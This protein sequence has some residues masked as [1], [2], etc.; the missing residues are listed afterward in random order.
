MYKL[1][2]TIEQT[3]F[4]AEQ[5]AVIQQ[6]LNTLNSEQQAWLGGYLSRNIINLGQQVSE[7]KSFETEFKLTILVGTQTGNSQN[8]A[9]QIQQKAIKVGIAVVIH[10]LSDYTIVQLKSDKYILLIVSTYGEGE[11][12]DN[13]KDFYSQLFSKRAPKLDHIEFS[14]LALGDSSYEH[15]CKIGKDFDRRF[16]DLGAKRI[17][18]RVDCD[19]DFDSSAELWTT[20]VLDLL[21]TKIA[22]GVGVFLKPQVNSASASNVD[23]SR[24]NPF[25][26]KLLEKV[27]INGRGSSKETYHVELS[28]E[29]SGLTYEPGDALG[30]YPTNQPDII[31]KILDTL[32]FSGHEL[33]TLEGQQYSLE[34]ALFQ[35][36]DITSLSRPII[37]NYSRLAKHATL[38]QLISEDYKNELQAYIYGRDILD[39]ITEY[40]INELS[41]QAFV[42]CLRKLS[43][44]LYSIASS[45]KK[46]PDEVHLTVGVV[47]YRSH[48]RIKHGVAS[49]FLADRI[50]ENTDIPI[51][52]HHNNNF[53]LPKDPN[54]SV[55]MI[56]PGTG[57]APFRAFM[58]ERD[59]VSAK[60]KN[61]LFFGDQHFT[62][63]FLYQAEW[64]RYFKYGLL[65][66]M[67]VAFSRDQ[68]D[69]IYVQHRLAEHA[70]Q[71]YAWL[72]D[73]ASIYVCGDEKN[74]AKDVH[75][76][77]V[78]IVNSESSNDDGEEFLARLLKEKRYQR[79]VY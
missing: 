35:F 72:Q 49:T 1:L 5:H 17:C 63:D 19:V 64:L 21:S 6:M 43:P 29:N 50:N 11:P 7:Q 16:E 12:P 45:L 74:M 62:T 71:L 77:L 79:D 69:K 42:D 32:H 73:G 13:T 18:E 47:R 68:T 38:E 39:L 24:K 31:Q 9:I 2:P 75:L 40:P 8:I 30:I 34:T 14:V 66:H 33:I 20:K 3:P 4:S 22:S 46:H 78:N 60:G 58:Q 61:W 65:T 67:D 54:T 55:I 52:I 36:F 10:D 26:A 70:K 25:P 53:K 23:Y 56:G 27:N 41:P 48:N 59:A 15:F 76:A 44:R 51:Y 37:Q 57:I 28:M